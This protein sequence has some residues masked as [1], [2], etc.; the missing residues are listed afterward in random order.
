[1]Q[2]ECL[3]GLNVDCASQAA[4]IT[5]AHGRTSHPC[6]GR[7]ASSRYA[8]PHCSRLGDSA[9]TSDRNRVW[10]A[11]FFFVRKGRCAD[12]SAVAPTR[13]FHPVVGASP[14][15]RGYTARELR[16][17][18]LRA[19]KSCLRLGLQSD[20]IVIGTRPPPPHTHTHTHRLRANTASASKASLRWTL[21]HALQ[22]NA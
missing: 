17:L 12:G 9:H 6:C 14:R 10:T 18:A 3:R 22:S 5:S 7:W 8:R 13:W 20:Y 15:S 1:M 16:Q 11:K 2:A 21:A 19:Y 4:A